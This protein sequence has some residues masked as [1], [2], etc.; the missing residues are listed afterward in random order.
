MAAFPFSK[1]P[2]QATIFT[3]WGLSCEIASASC[4]LPFKTRLEY[5]SRLSPRIVPARY[6]VVSHSPPYHVFLFLSHPDRGQATRKPRA[7]SFFCTPV[8]HGWQLLRLAVQ[9]LRTEVSARHQ[10]GG[11]TAPHCAAPSHM[12]ATGRRTRDE[13]VASARL[14]RRWAFTCLGYFQ[15]MTSFCEELELYIRALIRR[16]RHPRPQP[17]SELSCAASEK[18]GTSNFASRRTQIFTNKVDRSP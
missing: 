14:E 8:G 12:A 18:A 15:G 1:I 13:G 11:E 10:A 6:C 7:E 17:S 4:S 16:Q 9:L 5:T 2:A 3:G